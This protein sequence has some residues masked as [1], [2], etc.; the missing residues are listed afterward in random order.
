MLPR[1]RRRPTVPALASLLVLAA[2]VSSAVALAPDAVDA[3]AAVGR[4][5]ERP[6]SGRAISVDGIAF[7][8]P[9]PGFGVGAS[10]THPDG[11]TTDILVT[12]DLDGRVTVTRDAPSAETPAVEAP[13]VE[14]PAVEAPAAET[15][16]AA[17]GSTSAKTAVSAACS[18]PKYTLTGSAWRS[19]FHWS[20]KA[21]STP[22]N[23]AEGPGG[24]AAVE[25]TLKHAVGNITHERNDCGRPDTVSARAIY[26]GRTNLGTH[27]GTNAACNRTD[28]HNV[29]AFGDLPS[30]TLGFT[31][32]W[33]IG[34]RTIEADTVLNRHDFTFVL[35]TQ[36]CSGEYILEGVATHEF[37]HVFGL[38]HVNQD[39]HAA[40][41]MSPQIYPCDPSDET[42]GLGDMMGLER[43]Y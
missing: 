19:P 24:V 33:F 31:C 7:D 26:D 41:T 4:A 15:P 23:L 11:S 32:W 25:A 5:I 27:I 28:G 6:S 40:L 34:T 38:G 29:I 17:A 3:S 18:D 9:N 37:G 14:A 42:L 21:S 39:K 13:A 30:S 1:F 43:L 16:A 10:E 12:T 22:I 2:C 36:G 8:V 35:T 20:F